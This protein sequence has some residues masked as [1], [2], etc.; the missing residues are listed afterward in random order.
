MIGAAIDGTGM[1][2][3]MIFVS[4]KNTTPFTVV[5]A[6]VLAFELVLPDGALLLPSV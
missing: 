6:M 3:E 5:F 4:F 2:G 1:V